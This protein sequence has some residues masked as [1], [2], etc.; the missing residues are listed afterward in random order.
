MINTLVEFGTPAGEMPARPRIPSRAIDLHGDNEARLISQAVQKSIDLLQLSSDTFLDVRGNCV[1]CHHQNLPGVAIAWARERGFHVRRAAID[2]MI[3]RQVKS[4]A[5]RVERAYELDAPFPV[6]PR[7]LGYGMWSFA[8]LGYQPDELTHAVSWFLAA[9][10]QPDGRWTPGMLRPPMGGDEILA[11]TLA[12]RSLQLYPM[13]GRASEAAERIDRARRW[14]MEAEPRTHQE[15]VFRL[16]GLAWAGA[17]PA[18][19][20]EEVRTLLAAQR[21]DGG[22][23]QL[24][25]LESDAW[26]TGQTLVALRTAGGL[27]TTHVA[28]QRGVEMLLKTQFDDGS[29]YV[30]SRSW[31]FQPYFESKFPFG[32]DQWVSAPATAWAVMA[33]VLAIEPE[34]VA[35]WNIPPV[36]EAET[37]LSQEASAKPVS[38]DLVPAAT[39]VVDFHNDVKPL[40]ARSCLGCHGEKDA[41]A[42]LSL[43]SRAALIRGG[44]SELPAIVPGASQDSPLIRFAAGVVPEMEMP[45]LDSRDNYPPLSPEEISLL[46]AWID[47]GAAWPVDETAATEE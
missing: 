26:A 30:Q 33:L 14:L 6:P 18:A 40:F 43:T 47:Q 32:R 3:E 8:E 21:S 45:P 4:W 35:R 12:M 22:W 44:D 41:E 11:T 20:D 2:R 24:P 42:N 17:E 1:S 36:A 39:R 16:L 27:P 34:D 37:K 15:E 13:P 38:T 7:F 31:P 23:A 19:L 5:P 29:W 25:G 28:Y 9:T 46:R 10:Q